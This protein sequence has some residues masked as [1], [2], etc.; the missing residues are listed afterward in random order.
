M[1]RISA[2][3][4]QSKKSLYIW[5]QRQ[6][7]LRTTIKRTGNV[8]Q[9]RCSIIALNHRN[10]RNPNPQNLQPKKIRRQHKSQ[11]P[12]LL[13]LPPPENAALPPLKKRCQSEATLLIPE[14]NNLAQKRCFSCS[15][16]CNR[17]SVFLWFSHS[18]K[19]KQ[20]KKGFPNMKKIITFIHGF[21][22]ALADSEIGRASCRE[23][24]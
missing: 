16:P 3:K 12:P 22:M 7:G 20:N 9:I 14:K 18:K 19:M 6:F 1:Q 4:R 2:E 5:F 24:V 13:L 8:L 10:S 23:R 15:H 21:C 17:N 11:E